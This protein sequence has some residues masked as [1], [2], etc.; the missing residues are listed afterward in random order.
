MKTKIFTIAGTII[1]LTVAGVAIFLFMVHGAN[2]KP[3]ETK[4]TCMPTPC[5][6]PMA[7]VEPTT[8]TTAAAP[9]PALESKTLTIPS[10]K[11][12]AKPTPS[13][14]V[15]VELIPALSIVRLTKPETIPPAGEIDP[16]VASTDAQIQWCIN[17]HQKPGDCHFPESE[18]MGEDLNGT[19]W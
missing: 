12:T 16:S 8:A 15:N 10:A 9:R 5:P 14:T 1:A 4:S 3:V 11:A 18:G 2:A 17:T 19:D 6:A 13:T 7:Y